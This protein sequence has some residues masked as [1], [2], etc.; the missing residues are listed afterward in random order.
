MVQSSVT[1]WTVA[2]MFLFRIKV[3]QNIKCG[4]R[5][6][7]DLLPVER[8][9]Q[10]EET[11]RKLPCSLLLNMILN[12]FSCLFLPFFILFASN[13]TNNRVANPFS[14]EN[15]YDILSVLVSGKMH[16]HWTVWVVNSTS[17][18]SLSDSVERSTF[19]MILLFAFRW[20]CVLRNFF[21]STVFFR[22]TSSGYLLNYQV[23]NDLF[24]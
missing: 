7:V 23:D 8:R 22:V 16:K 13:L 2:G 10:D 12:E 21:I 17:T 24:V 5:L 3:I 19:L 4:T 11:F 14:P 20:V 15:Y 1:T 18:V 6:N 9:T